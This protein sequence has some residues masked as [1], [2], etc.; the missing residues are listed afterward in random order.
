MAPFVF[1]GA[2]N[3]AVVDTYFQE[4]LFKELAPGSVLVLDNASFHK[5]PTTLA[6]AKKAGIELLFL[7]A[8]SPD[9]NPIEH[10]WAAFKSRLQRVLPASADPL[11]DI[12]NVSLCFC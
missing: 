5:A 9:L 7:P 1:E 12:A 4:V 3:T 2:C 6:L 11:L 10:I 8:Y